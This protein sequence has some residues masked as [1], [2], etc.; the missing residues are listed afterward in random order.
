VTRGGFDPPSSIPDFVEIVKDGMKYAEHL[1]VEMKEAIAGCERTRTRMIDRVDELRAKLE[2]DGDDAA[3]LAEAEKYLDQ[4]QLVILAMLSNL[5]DKVQM[6]ASLRETCDMVVLGCCLNIAGIAEANLAVASGLGADVVGP[7]QATATLAKTLVKDFF[8]PARN[9]AEKA[10]DALPKV[11]AEVEKI[12]W[13]RGSDVPSIIADILRF[14]S[15]L[16][17]L[18]ATSENTPYVAYMSAI[19]ESMQGAKPIVELFDV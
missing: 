4:F 1:A 16:G 17:A 11:L 13:P 15:E 5:R 12:R 19:Q 14:K 7:V 18:T 8:E 9:A 10:E 3:K 6:T 2:A